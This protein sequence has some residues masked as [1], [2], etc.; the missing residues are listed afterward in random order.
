MT[1]KL[2]DRCIFVHQSLALR[3]R[4]RVRVGYRLQTVRNAS[5]SNS[6]AWLNFRMGT[7]QEPLILIFTQTQHVPGADLLNFWAPVLA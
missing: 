4:V 6:V 1:G 2:A 5:P 3:E 7:T